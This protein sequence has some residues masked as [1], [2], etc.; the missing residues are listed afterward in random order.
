MAK[1]VTLNR[2]SYKI[3]DLDFT[4]VIC[5]LEGQG[6]DVFGIMDGASKQYMSFCRAFIMIVTG[7]NAVAAGK[8]LTKHIKNGGKINEIMDTFKELMNDAGFGEAETA[9]EEATPQEEAA[10]ENQ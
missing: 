8:L 5:D 6:I 1:Y 7:L 2:T 10:T 9:T 3:D 4:N